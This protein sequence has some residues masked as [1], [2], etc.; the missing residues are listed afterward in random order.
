MSRAAP[1]PADFV[2]IRIQWS[3]ATPFG[4]TLSGRA[5]AFVRE[6]LYPRATRRL[7]ALRGVAQGRARPPIGELARL[8]LRDRA[9]AAHQRALAEPGFWYPD[10]DRVTPATLRLTSVFT[11]AT[12]ALPLGAGGVAALR[13]ALAGDGA[14]GPWMLRRL[15]DETAAAARA[16]G[17][18]PPPAAPAPARRHPLFVGHGCVTWSDGEVR[19]WS[20]P[21]LRPKSP[22]YPRRY[23]PLGPSD[24]PEARH[25]VLLTHTHPDHFDPGSLLRF[26]G[27][28]LFLVPVIE[29]ESLLS[30]N[31]R[32]RL[33]QLGCANVVPLAWGERRAIGAFEVTALPFYGEQPVGWGQS[34]L[35][36]YNRGNT[37]AVR[38]RDGR[39]TLL[40]A[41]SGSDPRMEIL[42]HARRLRRELGR[43]DVLFSN[44]R[45]WRLYP[46]QY[47]PSSVPQYLCYVP[48]AA[49]ALPQRIML[50]PRELAA[51]AET[52]GARWVVPYAMGGARWY[53]ELGLG[54]DPLAAGRPAT[55]FDAS[56]R[57]L[58]ALA[59]RRPFRAAPLHA[60]QALAPRGPRWPRGSA[61]PRAGGFAPRRRARPPAWL[62]LAGPAVT[63]AFLQDAARAT[64]LDRGAFLVSSDDFCEIHTSPGR[65]G[66]LARAVLASLVAQAG[67]VTLAHDAPITGAAF[68]H[69]PRAAALFRR[70]HAEA[71]RALVA[72]A[73]PLDALRR[74]ARRPPFRRLAPGLVA[75]LRRSW[76]GRED[77][78]ARAR[79]VRAFGGAATD[80]AL[81]LAKLVHNLYRTSAAL[82]V[83]GLPKDEED[84]HRA[85]LA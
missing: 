82:G 68:A 55:A 73:D 81:L 39:V 9:T 67:A 65:P 35:A 70:T 34:A 74:I 37:W 12:L 29:R 84:W 85:V 15:L 32:R 22:R 8:V 48:D 28:T 75:R 83:A 23:Q 78:A 76:L 54:Y 51:V 4:A 59:R 7:L 16:A 14:D 6:A 64:T 2:D 25:A 1:A 60:G 52:L 19:L 71:F 47:L 79:F 66:E 46:P 36:E 45:R 5:Q 31:V 58:G 24:F 18:A 27:D 61:P 13:R 77:R 49:L 57:E 80:R 20:D 50:E 30:V 3:D 33:A 41:D 38:D 63:R 62:A 72:G 17:F 40:L 56:P 11:N 53:A 69:D 43:V 42:E 44:H 10:E 21:F 26:P